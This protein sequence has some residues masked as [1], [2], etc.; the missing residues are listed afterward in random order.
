M[1]QSY[2]AVAGVITLIF[3]NGNMANFLFKMA[4]IGTV[5]SPASHHGLLNTNRTNLVSQAKYIEYR[6]LLLLLEMVWHREY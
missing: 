1:S 2:V 5:A 6:K 3:A 4:H